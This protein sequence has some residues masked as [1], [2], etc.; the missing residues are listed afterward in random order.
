MPDMGSAA[1]KAAHSPA[2]KL[3]DG[4]GNSSGIGDRSPQRPQVRLSNIHDC[5]GQGRQGSN[6]AND[7]RH[8]AAPPWAVSK[9]SESYNETAGLAKAYACSTKPYP[10]W[11]VRPLSRHF[12]LVY[13]ELFAP[14]PGVTFIVEFFREMGPC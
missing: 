12:A 14:D 6:K 13:T 9:C 1:R 7:E 8:G 10:Y 4:A 11:R 3:S 2:P 5:T